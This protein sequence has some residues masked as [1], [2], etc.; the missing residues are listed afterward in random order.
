MPLF[1]IAGYDD[2]P[3]LLD[4][5]HFPVKDE[6]KNILEEIANDYVNFGIHLLD[7]HNG[8]RVKSI[9]SQKR[10]DPTDITVEIVRKWLQ[11]KGSCP[12]TWQIFLECLRKSKLNFAA[13]YIQAALVPGSTSSFPWE[14]QQQPTCSK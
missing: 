11:G 9:E 10:G 2:A 6:F 7:D 8:N 1:K 4:L 14:Q 12:V 3:S 13:D 5:Q